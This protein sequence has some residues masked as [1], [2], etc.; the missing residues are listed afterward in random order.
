MTNE[1]QGHLA[2][3]SLPLASKLL[4]LL[5]DS[6]AEAAECSRESSVAK[7]GKPGKEWP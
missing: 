2:P 5:W 3:E 7:G 4:G 1:T 6:G